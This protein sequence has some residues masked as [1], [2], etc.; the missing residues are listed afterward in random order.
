MGILNLKVTIQEGDRR[1]SKTDPFSPAEEKRE[2][3][4]RHNMSRILELKAM[5][6]VQD[7]GQIVSIRQGVDI[8]WTAMM[9]LVLVVKIQEGY[10]R[11]TVSPVE[12]ASMGRGSV[13][14]HQEMDVVS[15]M[16]VRVTIQ[17]GVCPGEAT[18]H[19]GSG[20]RRDTKMTRQTAAAVAAA[21][22][23]PVRARARVLVVKTAGP[24]S[25]WGLRTKI[26]LW[27]ETPD[28]RP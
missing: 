16:F 10:R 9:I 1:D 14:L 4:M 15:I 22:I 25:I 7:M 18:T 8:R 21:A 20:A 17:V 28:R 2:C 13:D 24:A 19:N 3:C 11:R 27:K 26:W 23:P 12:V 6:I 5:G